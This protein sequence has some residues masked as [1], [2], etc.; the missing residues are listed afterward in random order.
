MSPDPS[1]TP[2]PRIVPLR[3]PGQGI[4]PG[5]LAVAAFAVVGLQLAAVMILGNVTPARAEVPISVD[6]SSRVTGCELN[7]SVLGVVDYTIR[8]D[9]FLGP[10]G[11]AE[12]ALGL[13]G[14][15]T[16]FWSV[17]VPAGTFQLEEN[18]TAPIHC[19]A[20]TTFRIVLFAAVP[21]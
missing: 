5:R 7:T 15:M 2:V 20:D 16:R 19:A 10:S 17:Y 12:M 8:Y 14:H 18:G 21:S 6:W 13:E 3:R 11:Y 1:T 9:N 4:T